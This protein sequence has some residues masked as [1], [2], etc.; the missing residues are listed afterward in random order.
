[1]LAQHTIPNANTPCKKHTPVAHLPACRPQGAPFGAGVLVVK[2]LHVHSAFAHAW[3][4]H[5]LLIVIVSGNDNRRQQ[6]CPCR[7]TNPA[8]LSSTI[9]TKELPTPQWLASQG[10]AHSVVVQQLALLQDTMHGA[11]VALTGGGG[12]G[13]GENVWDPMHTLT[14]TYVK[15]TASFAAS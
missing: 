11:L 7:H 3:G 9:T 10:G 6:Q 13:G 14:P 1:M 4:R 15:Q 12:R 5:H 8:M 2:A